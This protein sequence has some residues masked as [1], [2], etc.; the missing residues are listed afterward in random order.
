MYRGVLG[1]DG[2]MIQ[3]DVTGQNSQMVCSI[4]FGAVLQNY[5]TIIGGEIKTFVHETAET[6]GVEILHG[7]QSQVIGVDD[8][9]RPDSNAVRIGKN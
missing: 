2:H 6:V 4:N 8:T 9:G 3:K 7:G 1:I 5:H